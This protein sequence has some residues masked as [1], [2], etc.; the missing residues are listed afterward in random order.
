MPRPKVRKIGLGRLATKIGYEGLA[1]FPPP[2]HPLSRRKDLKVRFYTLTSFPKEAIDHFETRACT[3]KNPLVVARFAD[4]IWESRKD[5]NY[6]RLAF[7]GYLDSVQIHKNEIADERTWRLIDLTDAVQRAAEIAVSLNDPSLVPR[8]QQICLCLLSWLESMQEYRWGLEVIEAL[9]EM[10]KQVS[11]DSMKQTYAFAERAFAHLVAQ[12]ADKFKIQ[13][14]YARLLARL[15]RSLGDMLSVEKWRREVPAILARESKTKEG[16][17]ASIISHQAAKAYLDLGM[18]KE[19][20]EMLAISQKKMQD[21]EFQEIK[22]PIEIPKAI[23]EQILR[24]YVENKAPPEILVGISRSVDLVPAYVLALD[25]AKE[26]AGISSVIPFG[27]YDGTRRVAQATTDEEIL[28][29]RTARQYV[30]NCEFYCLMF[31]LPILD[32]A[33]KLGCSKDTFVSHLRNAKGLNP[34]RIEL[35]GVGFDRFLAEDYV[36]CIHILVVQVEAWIRDLLYS[37]GGQT[38]YVKDQIVHVHTLGTILSSELIKRAFGSRVWRYVNAI[39]NDDLAFGL[40]DKVAHGLCE[41]SEFNRNKAALLIHVCLL[42]T[43]ITLI[44]A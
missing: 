18:K 24:K 7:S 23:H 41:T 8:V 21:V 36:S 31:L 16:L 17:A 30:M 4:I 5:V 32:K 35:L 13:I 19:S 39:L 15:A 12:N 42:L 22:V 44:R 37:M 29:A 3:S 9:L 27:L 11:Q 26:T 14:D 43:N 6:A 10:E 2:V 20:D 33:L 25:T 34:N 1:F 28:Q 38:T 40:R